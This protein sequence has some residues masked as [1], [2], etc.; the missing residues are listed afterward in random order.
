MSMH[1]AAKEDMKPVSPD[2]ASLA[3]IPEKSHQEKVTT[4]EEERDRKLQKDEEEAQ[5]KA[6]L[7]SMR[8]QVGDILVLTARSGIEHLITDTGT[9]QCWYRKVRVTEVSTNLRYSDGLHIEATE[10]A[11]VH[12]WIFPLNSIGN[13][14]VHDASGQDAS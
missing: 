3:E 4:A 14:L 1:S 9:M 5:R 7:V 13:R 10:N 11:N 2:A 12:G 6:H 8:F